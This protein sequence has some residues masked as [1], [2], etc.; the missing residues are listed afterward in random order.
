MA[1]ALQGLPSPAWTCPC[2]S[3]S[4]SKQLKKCWGGGSSPGRCQGPTCACSSALCSHL[5]GASCLLEPQGPD[6]ETFWGHI[7]LNEHRGVLSTSAAPGP[8]WRQSRSVLLSPIK[9]KW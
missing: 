5:Q 7:P 4:S 9:N 1:R 2:S 3:R 6:Q 8:S